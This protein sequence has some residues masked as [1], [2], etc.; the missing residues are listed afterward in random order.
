MGSD[1]CYS[2]F[3]SHRQTTPWKSPKPMHQPISQYFP[4]SLPRLRHSAPSPFVLSRDINLSYKKGSQIYSFTIK[5]VSVISCT[6]L[7]TVDFSKCCICW[8]WIHIRGRV[9]FQLGLDSDF[10][11]SNDGTHHPFHPDNNRG[12]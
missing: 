11:S 9:E 3:P 6:Q 10:K 2:S 12:L 4:S 8:I 5:C 1:W 7:G